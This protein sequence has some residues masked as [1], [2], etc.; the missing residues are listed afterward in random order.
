[1]ANSNSVRQNGWGGNWTEQKLDCFESYVRAYL[2][3]MNVYRDK[4]NWKLIYFDGFAGC[5]SRTEDDSQKEVDSIFELYGEE[6]VEKQELSVYQGAAE[7]VVRLEEQMRGFDFYYFIDLFEENCTKLELK[8]AEYPTKGYK[9]FRPGDANEQ[10]RQLAAALNRDTHFKSLALLD[11]F[12]MQLDWSVIEA[13]S[14]KSVDLWILVPS[15]MVI[16]RLLKRNGELMHPE[17]LVKFFGLSEKQIKDWFYVHKEEPTLFGEMEDKIVKR[18]RPIELIAELFVERLG[19]LFPYVTPKP[20]VMRNK[21]NVPIFHF[22]CASF[23]QTAVK[24]AQQIIDKR[25]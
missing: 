23:N 8:L 21:N 20:L 22:I 9:Q 13:I 6:V 16:N 19:E 18:S 1:M 4:Y 17:K 11:P 7:R 3:I 12:G 25:Q 10:T 14:G 24:I 5:G 2:T 15:G